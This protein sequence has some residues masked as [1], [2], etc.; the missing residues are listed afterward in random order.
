VSVVVKNGKI[1]DITT[2]SYQ[3]DEKFYDRASSTVIQE[4]INSQSTSVDA[5]SGA[6]YSSNGI[7]K[8][9]ENALTNAKL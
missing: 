6:T 7:M 5:V 4:I 3:D 1:T 9:V 8:A 2:L